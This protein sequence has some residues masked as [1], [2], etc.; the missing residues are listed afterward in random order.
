MVS[1]SLKL[2]S[3]GESLLALLSRAVGIDAAASARLRQLDAELVDVFVTTPF[4]VIAARR[5][6][7][8]ASRDGAVVSAG[9]LHDGL[10]AALRQARED[11]HEADRR[12]DREK[13]KRESPAAAQPMLV[14]LGPPRDPSWPGA[15][16]PTSGFTLIDT[17]PVD[18]VRELA[19]QGRSL[20]RQ[21]SGP[22]G[23]PTSLLNQAVVTVSA[24]EQQVEIPMRMIFACTS[25]GLIPG[26]SAPLDIPRYLRVSG[27]GRW[28]RVDAP[29]GSVYHSTRLSL[30]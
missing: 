11:E 28:V 3:G 19:D 20:A 1:E 2:L 13:E 12:E 6:K 30:F 27:K 25:L 5:V 21:F 4:D 29:F 23:P 7:G 8:E 18:V 22:L 9:S 16:P 14:E 26:F 15:L 17:L 10:K 24:G